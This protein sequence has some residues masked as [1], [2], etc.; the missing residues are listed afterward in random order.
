MFIHSWPDGWPCARP[1]ATA[2]ATARWSGGGGAG[3]TLVGRL[4]FSKITH[5][6]YIHQ[7][8]FFRIISL[9]QQMTHVRLLATGL[10]KSHYYSKSI[11]RDKIYTLVITF[12]WCMIITRMIYE[13]SYFFWIRMVPQVC[14]WVRAFAE[15]PG[16]IQVFANNRYSLKK[17]HFAWIMW[18]FVT[19]DPPPNNNQVSRFSFENYDDCRSD[20]A[21]G[22]SNS[23]LTQFIKHMNKATLNTVIFRSL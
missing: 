5:F 10:A 15:E 2:T 17:W 18:C 12:N 23:I 8:V 22:K 11:V 6:H 3:N 13:I 1:T 20:R 9:H 7:S 19:P 4:K 16:G 14:L 21:G